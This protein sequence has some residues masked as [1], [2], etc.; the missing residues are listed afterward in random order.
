MVRNF[1][2]YRLLLRLVGCLFIENLTERSFRVAKTTW[3][4]PYALYSFALVLSTVYFEGT[5]AVYYIIASAMT[6]EFTTS[7]IAVLHV[8][9]L[10]NVLVNF[11]CMIL[12][13]N[14]LLKFFRKCAQYESHSTFQPPSSQKVRRRTYHITLLRVMIFTAGVTTYGFAVYFG[15]LLN[16]QTPW[17]ISQV[18][19]ALVCKVCYFFNGSLMYLVVRSASEV[20]LWYVS[21][22][23]QAFEDCIRIISGENLTPTAP[24]CAELRVCERIESIRL[25]ILNVKDLVASINDIW[26]PAITMSSVCLLWVNCT[27]LHG[28]AIRGAKEPDVCMV[29][30]CAA[31]LSLCFFELALISHSLRDETQSLKESAQA[32]TTFR[33]TDSYYRQK[34]AQYASANW[35]RW[36]TLYSLCCIVA[37]Y[38]GEFA[39]ILKG[40]REEFQSTRSFTRFLYWIIYGLAQ[41]KVAVNIFASVSKTSEMVEFFREAERFEKD[42]NFQMSKRTLRKSKVFFVMRIAM[43]TLFCLAV[44]MNFS[45]LDEHYDDV[46]SASLRMFIKAVVVLNSFLYIPHDTVHSNVLRP[47]C[48]VLAAYIRSLVE[49]LAHIAADIDPASRLQNLHRLEQ[50]RLRI[51]TIRRLKT[52]LDRAWMWPLILANA[53]VLLSMSIDAATAF[54]KAMSKEGIY[55]SGRVQRLRDTRLR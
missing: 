54:G 16:P 5:L 35:C 23:K 18:F 17:Q 34:G 49:E 39:Y 24:S 31:Y 19:A 11:C 7:L 47:T 29:L 37:L 12:G 43:A 10:A 33:A 4:K 45:Y 41:V 48:E 46:A 50:V 15:V 6:R 27:A 51:G 44:V 20:I 13:S 36:Y 28:V 52:R 25:N 1:A 53:S 38:T 55:L 2:P 9:G 21:A 22:Q 32:A 14:K 3:K 30:I 26:S 40:S 42:A 8:T